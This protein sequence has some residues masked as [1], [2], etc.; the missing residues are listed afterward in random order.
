MSTVGNLACSF[1]KFMPKEVGEEGGIMP[2]YNVKPVIT[3]KISCI[4]STPRVDLE[5]NITR[6]LGLQI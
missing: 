2:L 4:D 6:V 1:G 5:M 3:L